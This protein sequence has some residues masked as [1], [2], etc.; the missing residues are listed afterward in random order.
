MLSIK[1]FDGSECHGN[2]VGATPT[3]K[4]MSTLDEIKATKEKLKQQ[5]VQYLQELKDKRVKVADQLAS[6]DK[7]I[8]EYEGDNSKPKRKKRKVLPLVSDET[9][10]SKII[11]FLTKNK[12]AKTDELMKA[13]KV[14]RGRLEKFAKTAKDWLATEGKLKSFRY[15][16]K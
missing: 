10:K 5:E 2:E 6:I 13:G 16:L 3:Y 14:S 8:S 7:E 11:E 1:C 9:L 4:M 12:E 15:K